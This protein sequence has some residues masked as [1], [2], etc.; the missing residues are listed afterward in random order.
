MKIVPDT[1]SL[2]SGIFW[3]FGNPRKIVDLW[4]EEK[5]DF[6]GSEETLGEYV[7][8]INRF[9]EREDTE[10]WKEFI[11]ENVTVVES[12]RKYSVIREDP[13][14]DKFLDVAVEA[15]ADYI[16]S[17]D[18]HLKK[19]KEFGGIKILSPREFLDEYEGLEEKD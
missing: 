18:K 9:V 12:S 4:R 15:E 3:K 7:E 19:L 17:S 10:Y 2:I 11:L 16:I 5:V 13:D 8:V 14:D 1:S 6:I